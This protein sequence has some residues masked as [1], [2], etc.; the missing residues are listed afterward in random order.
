MDRRD[1]M[2]KIYGAAFPLSKQML[3][4]FYPGEGS[5]RFQ[6]MVEPQP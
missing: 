4:S 2:Q 5:Q 1:V 3:S 6:T